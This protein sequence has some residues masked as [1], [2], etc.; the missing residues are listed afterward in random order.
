VRRFTSRGFTLVELLVVIAIIGI[1]I[2]L[3]LPAVN[4]AREAGRRTQC[5]NNLT[6]IAKAFLN[7]ESAHQFL[8]TGG[9]GFEWM[10]DPDRG[11]GKSQPGGW[12]YNI[13][14]DID[15]GNLWQL[16]INLD[17]TTQAAQKAAQAQTL[18]ATTISVY[19]CPSRRRLGL[20]PNVAP[21]PTSPSTLTPPLPPYTFLP[22]KVAPGATPPPPPQLAMFRA[23]YAASSGTVAYIDNSGPASYTAVV[24]PDGSQWTDAQWAAKIDSNIP[25]YNGVCFRH[26]AVSLAEVTD[27][28]SFTYLVGEKYLNPLHY[29]DG[30]SDVDSRGAF[31]GFARDIV[32]QADRTDPPMRDRSGQDLPHPCFGSAHADGWNAAFC[33][34]AVHQMSY[35]IDPAIHAYLGCRND[36]NSIDT[37]KLNW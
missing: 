9:W 2:G 5:Q 6:Q 19:N 11:F 3:L 31:V 17:P 22:S 13:L 12:G 24:N 37:T 7:H 29:Y 33:D 34:G 1:L 26:S 18:W 15:Q 10:G 32:C 8:P 21:A 25:N 20:G 16:G 28:A 23:D 30:L 4:S 35:A 14:P 27:G 36:G